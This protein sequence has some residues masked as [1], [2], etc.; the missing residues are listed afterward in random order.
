MLRFQN[1]PDKIFMAIL[2]DGI[3]FMIDQLNTIISSLDHI[4]DRKSA[5]NDLLP[6]AGRVFTCETALKTLKRMLACHRRPGLY[7]LNDY[8]Y[9]L[10]Y[11]TL[12][13]LCEVHNDTVKEASCM[14]EVKMA[15]KVGKYYI[16]KIFFDR[17]I[18]IYFY[19]IDFLIN[20]ETMRDLGIEERKGLG[21]NEETFGI[22]QGLAPHPEELAVNL[23]KNEKPYLM[24]QSILWGPSSRV[25]P[26]M[27]LP[28]QETIE[29]DLQ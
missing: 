13:C 8:H 12:Q 29:V 2:E 18:E 24:I 14:N 20:S 4:G 6:F 28:D 25:Y 1:Y 9:L 21:I 11:D 5:F 10:L 27:E 15:S 22:S 3:T 19:D 7:Y 23:M 16:E 17:L 26:D